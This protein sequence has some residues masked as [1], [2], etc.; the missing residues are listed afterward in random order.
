[1]LHKPLPSAPLFLSPLSA[2][3]HSS[4]HLLLPFFRS[5][6]AVPLLGLMNGLAGDGS[7]ECGRGRRAR[8]GEETLFLS[9]PSLYP[10]S[11]GHTATEPFQEQDGTGSTDYLLE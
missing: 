10:H 7:C 6:P 1:M 8:R 11:L 2:Y 3:S 4:P 5:P 9:P